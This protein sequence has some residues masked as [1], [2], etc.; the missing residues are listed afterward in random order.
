MPGA[1]DGRGFRFRFVDATTNEPVRYACAP[2]H[3]VINP[4]LAPPGG[5]DDVHRAMEETSEASGLDF[6][7]DGETS[8]RPSQVRP[9]HQPE[10]Y[11][12]RW[13]PLLLAW[14]PDL[15]M[16]AGTGEAAGLGGSTFRTNDEGQSVYVT[17]MAV[18]NA[19]VD[20]RSGYGGQT[21]GQVIVHEMGHV[22]GLDH[23]EDPSSVMNSVMTLRPATWGDGDRKGLWELGLGRECLRAPAVP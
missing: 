16:P 21:W 4:R 14:A 13:A 17:G 7:Y 20:L 10:R 12:D 2:I 9:P 11:G 6:V 8:E 19:G 1:L 5:I 18:F 15:G 3:Y 22:V 23:I